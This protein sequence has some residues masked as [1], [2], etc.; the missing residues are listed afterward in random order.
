MMN[1]LRCIDIFDR[2]GVL[3]I[4]VEGWGYSDSVRSLGGFI[5][6]LKK[7]CGWKVGER[8]GECK[9]ESG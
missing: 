8:V 1:T 3:V 7:C 4:G 6:L 2:F 5:G 9:G